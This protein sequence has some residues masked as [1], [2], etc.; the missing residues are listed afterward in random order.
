VVDV[1]P[2]G[3]RNTI[4]G[5]VYLTIDMRHPN[6]AALDA[7][8]AELRAAAR[9]AEA[10]FGVAIAIETIWTSPPVAFDGACVE[11]VRAATTTL[12]LSNKDM[13]SG[14]G[15]DSCYVARVAPTAMIFVPC[16]K[17]ISHNEIEN[18]KKEH[19]EAGCN[20]LL[21]AMLERANAGA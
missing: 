12:G 7:M 4:A 2:R 16:E 3:S 21:H 17:G 10:E 11:A 1:A 8:D 15:H 20:V 13:V 5:H 9:A 19:L 6:G 18:A 14:A